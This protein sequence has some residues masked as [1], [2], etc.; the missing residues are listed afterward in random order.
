MKEGYIQVYTGEGKGKTTAALGLGMRAVGNGLSVLMIQFLKGTHS[1]ELAAIEGLGPKFRLRR[2][3]ETEK[4]VFQMSEGE[5]VGLREEIGAE[6]RWLHNNLEPN[7]C[8]VLILDE[9]LGCICTGLLSIGD[10]LS[11]LDKK[12]APMEMVLTGRDAPVE[13]VER[14]DLVTEMIAVKHYMDKGVAARKGI[15]Y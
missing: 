6:L 10:V 3:G 9:I 15:E 14:A 11:L 4:F 2:F 12:P 8:N 13:I 5:Q 1:G 7:L